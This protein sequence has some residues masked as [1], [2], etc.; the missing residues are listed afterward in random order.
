MLRFL[1]L[2]VVAYLIYRAFRKTTD[3]GRRSTE[4]PGDSEVDDVMIQD[5]YCGSYFPKRDAVH[6]RLDGKDL[7]FCSQ[8]CK[9]SFIAEQK[10]AKK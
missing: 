4:R 5:P 1:I 10:A 8:A 2:I 6:L 7:Y 9:Q 3:S